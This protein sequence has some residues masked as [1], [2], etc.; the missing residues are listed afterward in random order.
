MT[1]VDPINTALQTFSE[2]VDQLEQLIL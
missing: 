2:M 1:T